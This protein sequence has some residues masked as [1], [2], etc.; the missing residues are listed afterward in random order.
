MFAIEVLP[1]RH[2]DALWIE[3]GDEDAPNRILVD[4]GPRSRITM[5]RLGGLFD[6]R[7][8]SRPAGTNDF[9]LIVVSHIDAD[10]ITGILQLFESRELPLKPRD[11]WFNAWQHLPTDLLGAKQGEALSAAIVRRGL[12]WNADFDGQAVMVPDSGPLPVVELPD[13]MRLTL[14]SPTR[15]G[16]ARL[17]PVWERE[18]KKAGMVPGEA[19]ERQV[20]QPDRLGDR[21]IDP[22]ALAAEPF[23]EDG[24]AANGA[25]IAMLA[26]F[27]GKALLLTGDAHGG[28]LSECLRRLADERGLAKIRV[29]AFKLS[30]HGS[31]YNVSREV[32]DLV[33]CDRYLFSTNGDI[34]GHPDPVAVSRVI[35]SR[36]ECTLAF[37]YR[38]ETTDRWDSR[39]LRRRFRYGAIYP[40]EA[41]SGI[42]VA[43]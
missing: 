2:G 17:R 36:S 35:A 20:A 34:F 12:P 43:L 22:D 31:K 25:S 11:V 18:V 1:A 26:E 33:D 13:G 21:E 10:H 39:R 19:G 15:A 9:E 16:L 4:G 3:Y 41:D 5:E 27:D 23:E 6:E 14:L 42:R 40:D 28:T 32:L 7:V 30:H 29:D 38:T 8:R 24:S 37:N